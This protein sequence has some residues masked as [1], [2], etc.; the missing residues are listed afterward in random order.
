[1]YYKYYN[2]NNSGIS[3]TIAWNE[4]QQIIFWEWG[5]VEPP[6]SEF[7]IQL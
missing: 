1:M 7:F 2:I 6:N 5:I 4:L 3:Y